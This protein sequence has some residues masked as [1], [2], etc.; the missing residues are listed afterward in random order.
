[1]GLN[2]RNI[3]SP[4]ETLSSLS[5]RKTFQTENFSSNG[6]AEF[7]FENTIEEKN[8]KQVKKQRRINNTMV[9]RKISIPRSLHINSKF[10]LHLARR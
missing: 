4:L 3:A 7:F 8:L 10:N 2:N 6:N 1:M 9:E 5:Q